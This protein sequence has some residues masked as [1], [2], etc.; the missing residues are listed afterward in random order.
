MKYEVFWK[1]PGYKVR[2]ELETNIECDYLIV[3][4]GVTGVSAAYFLAKSGAKNIVLVE[5]HQIAS[6]ATGKAA[7]TLVLRGERDLLDFID[8]HGQKKGELYWQEIHEGLSGIKRVINEEKIDCDAEP[9]DTLY[10][11]FKHKVWGDLHEEYKAEKRLEKTT[12]L[13]TGDALK[14][15]INTDYFSHGILSA[16]HGLSVNPLKLTQNLS[17]A[18]EK[19]GVKIYE[20]TALLEVTGDTAKTHRG[21]IKY[22]KL[23]WA[24]DVD[25]PSSE[26]RNL[27][28]TIV[29]TQLLTKDELAE[30][31]L[32]KKKIVFDARK[33]ENYFKVTK[34]GRLLFGFGGIKVNKTFRKTEPHFPHLQELKKFMKKLFPYLKLEPEYAWTGNF[35][36]GKDYEPFI[37]FKGNTV[38]IAGASTQVA[39][40]MTA[41][42]VVS[43]LLGQ[44]STLEGFFVS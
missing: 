33:N 17:K 7:G 3:G 29:V 14:K 12:E 13:L 37:E 34:D 10:C 18:V 41:K 44:K 9:Q 5:K 36:I 26:V 39:C 19:Y 38:A 4:G 35:G 32:A 30:T 27:K 24:I 8:K 16:N 15:E 31:G 11:G 23:I 42:H 6:G 2:P 40:F 22:K 20:N 43:K 21:D 25:H 1:N 28:T